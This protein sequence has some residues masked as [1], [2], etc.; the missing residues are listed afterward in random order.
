MSE[1]W[2][3]CLRQDESVR[4]EKLQIEPP[5]CATA[6]SFRPSKHKQ[7]GTA[8]IKSISDALNLVVS[9]V[10]PLNLSLNYPKAKSWLDDQLYCRLLQ[11]DRVRHSALWTLQP[12]KSHT[13]SIN[14]T[15]M[16]ELRVAISRY[17][18]SFLRNICRGSK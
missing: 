15:R 3:R 14:G 9:H 11:R 8:G 1:S 18:Y 10:E 12:Y 6:S 13:N 16:S 7:S 4:R 17:P 5:G 2:S